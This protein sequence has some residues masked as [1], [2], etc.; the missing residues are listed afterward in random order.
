MGAVV[1]FHLWPHALPG[2]FV[3][4]DIFFV[5]SG[6]LITGHLT[7][8]LE[9][10]G[11]IALG[12]FWARRIRRLLPAAALILCASLAIQVF[13]LPGATT[14][15]TIQESMAS[16]LYVQNWYLAHKA[17]DY[18]AAEGSASL[19]Q[20]Y[21]SLSLEE[22]FYFLWPLL[23]LACAVLAR[24]RSWPLRTSVAWF[25]VLSGGASLTLSGIVT[26]RHPSFAFFATPVRV[27][28]FAAGALVAVLPALTAGRRS[29]SLLTWLA[30][31][32]I[33]LST[34]YIDGSSGFPGLIAGVP[35]ASA[36]LL[37]ALG[38]DRDAAP[39]AG[40]LLR[41]RVVQWLGDH[42]Y[43]LYLW[44]WPLVIAAQWIGEEDAGSA[45]RIAILAAL[46]VL[47][48]LTK[49]YVE[50]PVRIG[51]KWSRGTFR[52][53]A[54]AVALTVLVLSLG[55][56]YRYHLAASSLSAAAAADKK[57]AQGERCY[58]AAAIVDPLGCPQ[59]F[60]KPPNLDL[61]FA[62]SDLG[63]NSKCQASGSSRTPVW[64][65]FGNTT[66]PA[67]V[68]AVV[69]NSHALRL[70]PAM[71]EFGRNRN[72]KI[73]LAAKVD[74]LGVNAEA[75]AG[76][77]PG[78]PCL[79]W[80]RQVQQRLHATPGLRAVLFASHRGA[81][82][83]V[84]GPSPTDEGLHAVEQK[85]LDTWARLK[86][87]GISV[88][89]TED[90]PGTRPYLAPECIAKSRAPMAPCT[91]PRSEVVWDNLLS[92]LAKRASSLADYVPL[93]PYFCDDNKCHALVGGVVVYSD[94]HH[95]TGTYAKT[96]GRYLGPA[97]E[98]AMEKQKK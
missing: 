30:V 86:A 75:V 23:L 84:A 37:L 73:L 89:V 78:D 68:I 70:V 97:L 39:A 90:V 25:L 6:F 80:T 88:V 56:A 94:S 50:D 24:A 5:I 52:S 36:A 32:T 98:V 65:E 14:Q 27:W 60:A 53:Y 67:A 91:M 47:G 31:T 33:A 2:G 38:C 95:L 55:F 92:R 35:V 49:R 59:A 22:Q 43:S 11:S 96:L 4:V 12:E 10:T 58:G 34:K 51:R 69:G 77:S 66:N 61:A 45:R 29:R 63:P 76:Q 72:W 79:S 9:R 18:L 17:V 13:F 26:P 82:F 21:W 85:I 93:A 46:P 81:K 62:V 57:I 7:R 87:K 74:C 64:C 42:S 44:H 19:V 83:M 16:A 48:W 3:G 40:I 71:E 20:H 41:N 15:T 54:L 8:E 1:L 28:E